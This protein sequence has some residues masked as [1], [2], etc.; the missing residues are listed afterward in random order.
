MRRWRRDLEDC[1]G[2]VREEFRRVCKAG[3][4]VG[5]GERE[6][7]VGEDGDGDRAEERWGVDGWRWVKGW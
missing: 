5:E 3:G 6:G 7:E 1:V 2:W 4:W